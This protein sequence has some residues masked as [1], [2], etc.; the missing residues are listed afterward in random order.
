MSVEIV[1]ELKN[2]CDVYYYPGASAEG[3]KD[4]VIV[5]FVSNQGLKW[6]GVFA[7]GDISRNAISGIFNLSGSDKFYIISKGAGYIISVNDPVDWAEI[8]AAPIL[9]VKVSEAL[10]IIVFA[11]Y[12][13]LI[14]Y[15]NDGIVWRSVQ[16]VYD[17]F[18]I[19]SVK[20]SILIG[21]YFDPRNDEE[22]MFEVDLT[23]GVSK[24]GID[25]EVATFGRTES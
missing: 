5:S 22:T 25:N 17:G 15:N 1:T 13:G 6:Q 18:K 7:F 4:G 12:T 24:G 21:T 19:I 20:D 23:T 10:Q 11:D 8:D 16:L 14:A 2:G 3:G 9:N